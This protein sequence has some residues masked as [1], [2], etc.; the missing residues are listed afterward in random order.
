MSSQGQIWK[1][2]YGPMVIVHERKQSHTLYPPCNDYSL[3]L[4]LSL[5]VSNTHVHSHVH[6][7]P[8]TTACSSC[9][10][11][12]ESVFE[13]HGLPGAPVCAY[14]ERVKI[15]SGCI[16]PFQKPF[17]TQRSSENVK[18]EQKLQT[19]KSLLSFGLECVLLLQPLINQ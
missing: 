6:I 13:L 18:R 10:F 9:S 4:F 7:D 16:F 12:Y 17:K 15:L 5:S 3:S 19:Q 2:L 11:T 8:P 1:R 14:Y